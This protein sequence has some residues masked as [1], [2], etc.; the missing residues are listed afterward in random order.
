[1]IIPSVTETISPWADFSKIPPS[2]LQA[3]ADRGTAV[4]KLCARYAAGEFV[5]CDDNSL[6]GYYRGF[7]DWFD[8]MV[9]EVILIEERLVDD[10][11]GYHGMPDLVVH[12]KSGENAL[13]DL[14]TPIT[15]QRLWQIQIAA[16]RHLV[17]KSGHKIDK[18]GSLQLSPEGKTA[19]MEW[20]EKGAQ[21][22]NVFLSALNV[23]R[24]LNS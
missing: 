7:T 13:V 3:A 14:K 16:Y 4:H 5:V 23:Y 22:F 12:L 21:D 24:F 15:S 18:A 11:F 8:S 19:K 6:I 2:V 10:S 9:S 17:E 1:M 20:Y